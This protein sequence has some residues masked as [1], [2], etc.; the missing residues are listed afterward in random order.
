NMGDRADYVLG[1]MIIYEIIRK[2]FPN[3]W[4]EKEKMKESPVARAFHLELPKK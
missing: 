4:K 2:H 1:D 3:L